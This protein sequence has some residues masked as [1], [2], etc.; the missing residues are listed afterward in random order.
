MVLTKTDGMVKTVIVK[1]DNDGDGMITASD[2]RFALRVAVDL[3]TPNAWETDASRVAGGE[4]VT[5][6][7]ARA[8]LR[9]AVG[10]ENLKLV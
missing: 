9:A 1:G 8:I 5:A 6:A 10:L 4:T 7:D 3:E 2:A